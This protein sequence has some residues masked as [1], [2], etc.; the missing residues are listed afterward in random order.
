MEDQQRINL[1]QSFLLSKIKKEIEGERGREREIAVH[2]KETPIS[3]PIC[4]LTNPLPHP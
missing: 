3:L 4:T 1:N 2:E